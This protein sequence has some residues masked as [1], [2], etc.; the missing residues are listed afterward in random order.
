MR[1]KPVTPLRRRMIEDMALVRREDAGRLYPPCGA[2]CQVPR[3]LA[4]YGNSQR[5]A[6]LPGPPE[7][8]RSALAELQQRAAA[9]RL[10]AL[11]PA[12]SFFGGLQTR[13]RGVSGCV[14]KAG[15]HNP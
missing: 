6:P 4:G 3:P 13:A 2:L 5:S 9:R 10:L 7:R 14:G 15:I 1:D 12:S 11:P 8:D